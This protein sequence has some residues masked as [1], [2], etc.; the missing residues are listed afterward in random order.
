[1]LFS[2]YGTYFVQK[3]QKLK[4]SSRIDMFTNMIPL[5]K[6]FL[7]IANILQCLFILFSW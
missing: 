3:F 4:V 2:A 7:K 1:M 5:R 6:L